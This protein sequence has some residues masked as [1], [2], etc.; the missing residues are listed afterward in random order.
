MPP[1]LLSFCCLL[2][3][4]IVTLTNAHPA[5]IVLMPNSPNQRDGQ[6]ESGHYANKRAFDRLEASPFDFGAYSKRYSDDDSPF[7]FYRRKKSF[8]RLDT[9]SFSFGFRRKRAFDRLDTSPFS[10]GMKKRSVSGDELRPSLA[11]QTHPANSR[12]NKQHPLSIVDFLEQVEQRRAAEP[13]F[14]YFA[15]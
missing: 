9:S 5:G 7:D 2:L 8:D 1:T 11:A 15:P 4:L 12:N 14:L 3:C 6:L 13:S 10:F